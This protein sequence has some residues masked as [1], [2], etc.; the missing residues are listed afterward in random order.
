MLRYS[1]LLDWVDVWTNA[2]WG[3]R[4]CALFF[5]LF[6]QGLGFMSTY[7]NLSQVPLL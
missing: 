7:S 1:L 3:W 2:V 6:S 5:N 4:A